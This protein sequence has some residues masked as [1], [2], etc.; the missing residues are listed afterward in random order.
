MR[1]NNSTKQYRR[2]SEPWV[3][4]AAAK[5][6]EFQH[7]LRLEHLGAGLGELSFT[8]SHHPFLGEQ[9]SCYYQSGSVRKSIL[10]AE[11]EALKAESGVQRVS[12]GTNGAGEYFEVWG[13]K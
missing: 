12:Y 8:T 2:Y 6:A 4:G 1:S 10:K 3:E 7:K 9:V 11:F 13:G 5:E